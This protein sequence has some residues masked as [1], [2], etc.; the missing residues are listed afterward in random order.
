[1]SFWIICLLIVYAVLMSCG[2]IL[3]KLAA[4]SG[5]HSS[6]IDSLFAAYLN[7]YFVIAITLYF[8]LTI[9][10]IWLIKFVPLSKAYPI[11]AISFVVTPLLAQM[12]LAENL[13]KDLLIG[14]SLIITG[15][16]L[17]VR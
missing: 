5:T 8:G 14:S 6:R 11:V 3:F 12:I 17:I 4:N 7:P 9:F 15:I 10:W 2:Q 13:P 1:M 16:Y